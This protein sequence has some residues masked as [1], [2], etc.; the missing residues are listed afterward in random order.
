MEVR[1]RYLVDSSFT[2]FLKD[3]LSRKHRRPSKNPNQ[4]LERLKLAASIEK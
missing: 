4:R 1:S 3:E 2:S